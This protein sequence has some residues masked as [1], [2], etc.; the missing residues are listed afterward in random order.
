MGVPGRKNVLWVGHGWSR[1]LYS[2]G[3]D[4]FYRQ[5]ERGP[6]SLAQSQATPTYSGDI[7]FGIFANETGGKLFYDRNDVNTEIDESEE[8]YRKIATA[9]NCV[10]RVTR[11]QG[12]LVPMLDESESVTQ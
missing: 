1:R 4:W 5:A 6:C 9:D 8:L 11:K 12:T 3:A 10:A 2:S 7:N